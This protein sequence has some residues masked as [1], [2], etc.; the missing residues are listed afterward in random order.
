[1]HGI[2]QK[3]NKI[4]MESRKKETNIQSTRNKLFKKLIKNVLTFGR[5]VDQGEMMKVDIICK[6]SSCNKQ[7]F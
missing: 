2:K 7:N 6:A 5:A 3:D 4:K 1:M